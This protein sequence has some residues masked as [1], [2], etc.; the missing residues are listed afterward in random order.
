MFF[1]EE[2]R[3]S[4]AKKEEALPDGSFPIRNKEDLLHAIKCIGLSKDEERAKNWIKKRARE[5]NIEDSLPEDWI[6]KSEGSRGGKIIGH[7]KSG[8]PVY[9]THFNKDYSNFTPQ[10]H[11]ESAQLHTEAYKKTKNYD[12]REAQFFHLKEALK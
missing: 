1:S 4:L 10:D 9:E 8:K 11:V 2:K 6:Q 7:T 3:K 5:L 12:H